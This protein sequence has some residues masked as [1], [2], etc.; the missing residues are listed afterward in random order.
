MSSKLSMVGRSVV[1]KLRC[2][3]WALR[4]A[5]GQRVQALQQTPPSDR[6]APLRHRLDF[7]N[8]ARHI[9]VRDSRRRVNAKPVKRYQAVW[10]ENG[11]EYRE[12][13]DT[14]ELAQDKLDNV[15]KLLA[16][17]QSPASLRDRGIFGVVPTLARDT[18]SPRWM[19]N[20]IV[21]VCLLIGALH[22]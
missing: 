16:Q 12:T 3:S 2:S 6:Q 19:C 18:V 9:R 8:P 11:R 1:T 14:R 10:Y 7:G 17:G 4:G 22:L 15:K 20:G 21:G 13:F 5:P